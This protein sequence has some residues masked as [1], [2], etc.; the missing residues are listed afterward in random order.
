MR[1]GKSFTLIEL[2][3]VVAIIAILMSVLLPSLSKARDMAWGARCKSNLKQIG[4]GIQ[5]YADDYRG[6]L[7][8]G[9]NAYADWISLLW[10]SIYPGKPY[11]GF[12]SA[13]LPL[14]GTIFYCAVAERQEETPKRSY[15]FNIRIV[16]NSSATA[17]TIQQ[18]P[19]PSKAALAMDYLDSST[20]AD[21]SHVAL[22]HSGLFNAAFADAHAEAVKFTA[23]MLNVT[24]GIWS[25]K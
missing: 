24:N 10:P 13:E 18:I 9:P 21:P 5:L 16:D 17:E 15:G 8:Y 19:K 2:L 23:D 14:P 12:T 25:G 6:Y 22:R 20:F 7:P 4:S 11:V 1:A 3:V